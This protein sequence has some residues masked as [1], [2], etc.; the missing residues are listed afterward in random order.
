MEKVLKYDFYQVVMSDLE[1]RTFESVLDEANALVGAARTFD[2]GEYHVRL[3]ELTQQQG[4]F[5]GDIA[6]I[7]MND[8]PEKMRL[9]GER[10]I[11]DL[12]DDQGLGEI[13]SFIYNPQLRVL[14]LMRNR[15]AVT[16]TGFANYFQNLG[17]IHGDLVLEHIL[18]ADAYQRLARMN[19]AHKVE[20][21]IAAPGNGAI[22]DNLGLRPQTMAELIN[23]APKVRMDFTIS[24]DRERNLTLPLRAVRNMVTTFTR[25]HAG[26]VVKLIVTGK[27]NP[28]QRLD[29]VDL[30]V[31]VMTEKE[32]VIMQRNQ[33]A[34]A[35][36][37][38][39]FAIDQA[40]LR[41]LPDLNRILRD[42]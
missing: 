32:S 12:E 10:E 14:V 38:R 37:Q 31:E 26:E 15:F 16:A 24:M 8:I 5:R 40:Y 35:D 22:F 42:V 13:A 2:N 33:R 23:V 6:R 17:H 34:L 21:G 30:L 27:E 7:R 9:S 4:H 36:H 29:A 18:E 25:D 41:K 28:E 11:L 20:V 3:V 39:H 19:I 1:P